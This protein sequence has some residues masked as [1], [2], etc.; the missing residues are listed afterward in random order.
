M[1]NHVGLVRHPWIR[2]C[3][4]NR[5]G[6][7]FCWDIVC[8]RQLC[9]AIIKLSVQLALRIPYGVI[10]S[11]CYWG[12]GPDRDICGRPGQANNLVPLQTDFLSIFVQQ[13]NIFP[14]YSSD[15]LALLARFAHRAAASAGSPLG[16][17]LLR[18]RFTDN[19]LCIIST[20][21]ACEYVKIVRR[22]LVRQLS[23]K[24]TIC[25]WRGGCVVLNTTE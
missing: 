8:F 25:T 14:I 22:D 5:A 21:T 12:S 6:S 18:I 7:K 11:W 20:R 3:K 23:R 4:Q 13:F 17:A 15:V 2:P 24:T 19:F 1:G 10:K 9:H 16:P